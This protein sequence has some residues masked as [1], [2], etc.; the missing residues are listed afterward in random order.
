MSKH[1]VFGADG[2]L[3]ACYDSDFNGDKI[4]KQAKEVSEEI[5]ERVTTETD[6]TW[7]LTGKEVKKIPFAG[8][9]AQDQITFEIRTLE[10]SITP[11][12]IREAVLGMD[13]GWLA[14]VDAEIAALRAKL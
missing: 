10:A 1:L 7:I 3:A 14:S 2:V 9:S 13:D 6:G 4:P 11:R 12:R 5:Y 8:P